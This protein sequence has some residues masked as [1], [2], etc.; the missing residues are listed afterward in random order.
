[1]KS[2]LLRILTFSIA[3]LLLPALLFGAADSVTVGTVNASGS[4]VDVPVYIRDVAGTSLG[5]DRPTGSKIQS[6]SIK[7]TYA[8]ASAVTSV[9]FS[10]AGIT[11][12]LSPTFESKPSTANSVSILETF[13]EGGNTIPFTL[14]ASAPG[15]QVAHLV[16]NLANSAAP[17]STITL[18]LDPAVTQLTDEG[19]TAATK[20]T[21]ANSKLTLTDGAIHVPPLSIN[22]SPSSPKVQIGKTTQLTVTASANVAAATTIALTSSNTSNATVPASTIM[23]AGTKLATFSVS[24]IAVGSSTITAALP[25]ADGGDTASVGVTVTAQPAPCAVPIAPVVTAPAT[26]LS[27]ASYTVSWPAV[28]DATE[29]GIDEAIDDAFTSP[30]HTTT[31]TTSASFAHAVSSD[32]TYYYRVRASNKAASCNEVSPLSNTA[33]VLVAPE[34]SAPAKRYIPV[35]GSNPG[36]AG[37]YFKTAV[38]FYNAG[39]D[40]VSGRIV[41]HPAGSSATDADASLAYTLDPQKTLAYADLLP[42]MGVASGLGS[43]DVIADLGSGFPVSLVRVFND[44]GVNGT[45]GLVEELLR[46]EDAL[47]QGQSGVLIAPEDIKRFRLNIGVRSLE[48][49]TTLTVTVRNKDG[50]TVRTFQ[51]GFSP[52]YFIQNSSTGLLGYTLTGGETITFSVDA[53]SVFIYGATTDNKTNDPSVQFAKR[54]E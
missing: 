25:A 20:E 26:A 49:G 7:V 39:T 37:S 46:P 15:N 11:S 38:Q 5:V 6:F 45:S 47:Q 54:T 53:G 50:A 29:Y 17:G 27:G 40:A 2:R 18:T 34:P 35:V 3:S 43:V 22:L 28:T 12:G 42:A 9:T 23:A 36:T 10:R 1:M 51:Q 13:T 32:A 41:F 44:G 52:S 14:N 48:S 4:S 31:T 19:G 8:P 21:V 24:G 33:A 30:T 16:F